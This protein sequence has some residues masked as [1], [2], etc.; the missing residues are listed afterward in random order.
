[1]L[2][3]LSNGSAQRTRPTSCR[4]YC[5]GEAEAFGEAVGEAAVDFAFSIGPS[6]T[7]FASRLPSAFF[8]NEPLTSSFSMMSFIVTGFAP[9][10]MTV[11]SVT[12]KT[13]DC[14]LLLIV[15]V[16]A[17]WLTAEIIP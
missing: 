12:L 8:Q 14:S 1:M 5:L 16:F 9:F 7:V 17:F 15:N 3:R 4:S 2:G 6:F 13:R 10:V 11:L